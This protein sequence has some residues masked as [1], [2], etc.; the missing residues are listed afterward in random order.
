MKYALSRSFISSS[1]AATVQ[2]IG[3][4]ISIARRTQSAAM[5][6]STPLKTVRV[7]HLRQQRLQHEEVHADRR[8]DQAD[9][10]HHHDEDAEPDRVEPRWTISGKNTGTVSRIIDSSSIAVPSS[11]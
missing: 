3:K 4:A 6:G 10:D 7:R 5:N 2:M 11:T 9:L 8:A 1:S